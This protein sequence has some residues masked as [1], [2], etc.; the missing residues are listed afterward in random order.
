M[1]PLMTTAAAVPALAHLSQRA[2]EEDAGPAHVCVRSK[3]ICCKCARRAGACWCAGCLWL[4]RA[5]CGAHALASGDDHDERRR[6]FFIF[7][8]CKEIVNEVKHHDKR[9]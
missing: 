8:S 5:P 3:A 2:H 7:F 1:S 9:G 6:S 4:A